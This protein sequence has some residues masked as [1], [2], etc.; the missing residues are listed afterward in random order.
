MDSPEILYDVAD[1]VATITLNRPDKL[2]AFTRRMRDELIEA[3]A[4]ADR[5]ILSQRWILT[6]NTYEREN[7]KRIYYLSM[8]F[9]IER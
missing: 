9:L 6:E 8:E 7:P 1:R 3:F 5:D 4:R 2:N